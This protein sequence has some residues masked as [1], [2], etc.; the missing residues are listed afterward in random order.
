MA[1]IQRKIILVDDI[2][3][4]LMATR[5]RLKKYYEV[6]PAQSVTIL[7]NILEN[8]RPDLILL[9]I[10]MPDVDGYE[11]IKQ[12]KADERYN[13]IPVI[14]L[15]SKNDK[16]SALKGLELGAVDFVKKPYAVDDLIECIEYHLNPETQRTTKPI[17][18]AIDD[19]PSILETLTHILKD[20]YTVYTISQPT[21]LKEVLKRVTPD[22]FLLDYQM[23]H[24]TGF[25]L[26][27][28]IRDNPDHKDTPIVFLTSEGTV[29]NLTVAFHLGA[30][31][32]LVKPIDEDLL[33]EKLAESLTDYIVRRRIRGLD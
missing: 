13:E 10:N 24:L 26:I 18:L 23:P 20:L 1:K 30:D 6:Y 11:V 16:A 3:F 27:P 12:L 29:D 9:D 28:I 22:L 14:Y 2:N 15:T 7:F 8:M 21:F 19:S 4:H 25:D 33:L 5:E 32:F 31:G 17:V